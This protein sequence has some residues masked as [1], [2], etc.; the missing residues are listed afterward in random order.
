SSRCIN[1]ASCEEPESNQT[2]I[3]SSSFVNLPLGLCSEVNPS[4]NKSS[5][6][7]SNHTFDPCSKNSLDTCSTVSSVMIG[8][9]FSAYNT[10][11]GTLLVVFR[12]LHHSSPYL[13]ILYNRYSLQFLW[14]S[15]SLISSIIS[16]LKSLIDANY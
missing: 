2:S 1:T 16:C 15:Y 9:L 8:S 14:H 6:S 3:I 4:G 12:V 11:I 5:A 7:H 13:F 10:G